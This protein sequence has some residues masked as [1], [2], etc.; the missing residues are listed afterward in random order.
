MVVEGFCGLRW[1]LV[2]LFAEEPASE[3]RS[4]S[5]FWAIETTK[6]SYALS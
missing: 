1:R 5:R 3:I 6:K 2:N 4:V